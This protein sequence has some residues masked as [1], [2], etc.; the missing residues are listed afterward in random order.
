MPEKL[1]RHRRKL[2][3][4]TI[5]PPRLQKIREERK[6]GSR[7][8]TLDVCRREVAIAESMFKR[9]QIP[10]LSTTN[11]SIEEIASKI[12]ARFGFQRSHF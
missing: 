10:V 7:Y 12:V 11:T 8:A 1:R 3:G 4:L 9:E 2:F 5:D 6:P